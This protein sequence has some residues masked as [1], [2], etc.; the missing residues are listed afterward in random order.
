MSFIDIILEPP[1]YGWK[2]SNGDLITPTKR[3]LLH[4]FFSRLNI[5]KT[6]KNWLPLACWG[7]VLLLFPFI[8]IFVAYYFSFKLILVGFLYGMFVM[9]THGT[10]WYHRY[11]THEAY[12]FRN[13]FW[14]F[15]TQN[16]VPKMIPEEVYVVSHHVHHAKSDMPGDPYNAN[17]GFLYCFLADVN[18]QLIARD[19]S[20]AD[21]SRVSDF[22]KHTGIKRNTYRQYQ[23]WGSVS[24]P[25]YTITGMLLNL[26][27]W[28]TVFYLLGGPA[29]ACTLFGGAFFWAVGVRTFNYNGHG[30]GKDARLEG[31][32]FNNK[33]QS[34][35]QYWPGIVAGEWHNNHHLFPRSARAGFL[36]YQLDFAWYYIYFLY[37]IGGVSSYHNSKARF[38][39]DYYQPY[40]EK[41]KK[42]AAVSIREERIRE[43]V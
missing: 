28:F 1:G 32:D 27:F 20:E 9:G 33:D 22:L 14:R 2:D 7:S 12:K 39:T 15:L 11:S 29:I 35:N 43:D 10:I 40:M 16:L 8:I 34:V 41:V 19:L 18:H 42:G 4:E 17:G 5:F 3:Q 6:K 30:K 21:Y 26:A 23:R 13:K 37:L 31:K 38:L 24:N 25:L 36:K